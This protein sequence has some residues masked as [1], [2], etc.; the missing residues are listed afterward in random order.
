MSLQ[1]LLTDPDGY[2]RTH[3]GVLWNRAVTVVAGV[4]AFVA[5][6]FLLVFTLFLVRAPVPGGEVAG[7]LLRVVPGQLFWLVVGIG[8]LWFLY[9]VGLHVLAKLLDGRGTFGDTF[10]VAGLGMAPLLVQLPLSFLVAAVQLLV[11]DLGGDPAAAAARLSAL[12][13]SGAV[14]TLLQ[15]A[16]SVWSGWI[17]TA[18]LGETHDLPA[19]KALVAAGVVVLFDVLLTLA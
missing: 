11:L 10:A 7:A 16:A 5:V 2:V 1:T 17:W 3:R 15:V 13:A 14:T 6:G 8:F 18:G 4:T 19:G 9:A 12:D